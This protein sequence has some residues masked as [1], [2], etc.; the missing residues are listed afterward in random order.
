MDAGDTLTPATIPISALNGNTLQIMSD[1]LYAGGEPGTVIYVDVLNGLDTNPGTKASPFQTMLGAW[2]TMAAKFPG[3]VYRG[4]SITMALRCGQTHPHTADFTLPTTSQI[5]VSFYGD[6]KYGDF[7]SP[8]VAGTTNPWEM[9]DLQRPI[10]APASSAVGTNF[11]IAGWNLSGGE[12]W[13]QGVSVSLPARA[14]NSDISVVSAFADY[15]RSVSNTGTSTVSLDG[16]IFNITDTVAY[17]GAIGC[18]ARSSLSVRQFGT[19]FQVGGQLLVPTGSWT[20]T[21]LAARANFIKFYPDFA[22]N[23][24][25]QT[26]LQQTAQTASGGSGTIFMSWSDTEALVVTGTTTNQ[27]SFP[28]S[29]S[30]GFGL[31]N[32]VTGITKGSNGSYLNLIASR[33]M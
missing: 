21:Q 32:Y 23:N 6:P 16:S 8:Q 3:G 12:L 15:V 33:L 28:F 7:N 17:W 29:F 13:L 18:Q 2:N 31:V 11:K 24:Q 22:G 26:Y 19:Q 9:S 10:I 30:Q 20:S 4:H 14:S 27:Q 25:N 1:G 5:T